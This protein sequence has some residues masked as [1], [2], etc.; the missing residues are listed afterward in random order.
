MS[1]ISRG[2]WGRGS[3][4]RS[5]GSLW[6]D[7][8]VMSCWRY[9]RPCCQNRGFAKY[10]LSLLTKHGFGAW[11]YCSGRMS[12]VKLTYW[13]G[14]S[15]SHKCI[16]MGS[17]CSHCVLRWVARAPSVL[18]RVAR[19]P[20]KCIK[21]DAA[22]CSCRQERKNILRISCVWQFGRRRPDCI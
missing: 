10:I 13:M 20:V 15:C 3:V 18:W 8:N 12:T 16:M 22:V 2:R 6:P 17:P 9:M 19:A 21:K 7:L 14:S 4:Y 5:T 11:S 1:R